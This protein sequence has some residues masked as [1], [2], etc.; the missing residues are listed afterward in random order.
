MSRGKLFRFEQNRLAPNVIEQGKTFFDRAKGNWRSDYFKNQNPLIVEL[1]CGKGEYTVGLAR[2]HPD[3]NYIGVDKKG[4]RIARGSQTAITEQL[5]NVVFLRTD[6]RLID[7]FFEPEEVDEIWITFPDPQPRQEKARLTYADYLAK[8]HQILKP[9]GRLH[10]KTDS[11]DFFDFSVDTLGN[12]GFEIVQL[13]S[14]LYASDLWMRHF[15]IKTRYEEIFADKGFLIK[16]L[17]C[18]KVS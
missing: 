11:T 9:N 14:N 13:T 2:R 4:D 8:Y 1:A 12:G 16:Y 17:E 7:E 6:I 18:K 15:G 10:L 5:S 3:V